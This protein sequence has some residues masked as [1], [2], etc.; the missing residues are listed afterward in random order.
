M[1]AMESEQSLLL[2]DKKSVNA[3]RTISEAAEIVGVAQHVLRF[4]ETKINQIRPV[5]RRGRRYY[6]PEDIALLKEIKNLLYTEGYTVKGV[7]KTLETATR[8]TEPQQ[9]LFS[10]PEPAGQSSS[11]AAQTITPSDYIM[12]EELLSNLYQSRSRLA[13]ALQR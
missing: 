6:R 8:T 12:L 2:T 10:A 9:E 7:Q 1:A 5:K 3:L 11:P 4:W 13:E